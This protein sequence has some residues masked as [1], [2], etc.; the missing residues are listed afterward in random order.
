MVA[1]K[2]K[3]TATSVSITAPR[4]I[5]VIKQ[6]QDS[7]DQCSYIGQGGGAQNSAYSIALFWSDEPQPQQLFLRATARVKF[8]RQSYQLEKS[9]D[10][11]HRNCDPD[12]LG[13]VENYPEEDD[14]SKGHAGEVGDG[15]ERH[16]KIK[17]CISRF[18]LQGVAGFMR[19]NTYGRYGTVVEV[20]R[21]QKE[22]ALSRIVVVGQMPR[23]FLDRHINQPGAIKNYT[24]GFGPR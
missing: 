4:D 7:G 16:A 12:K 22:G 14:A 17:E 11:E 10:C 3:F 2:S 24:G 20:F 19:G 21:R 9:D 6:L 18:M 1:L 13:N 15:H 5:D 8:D 23:D